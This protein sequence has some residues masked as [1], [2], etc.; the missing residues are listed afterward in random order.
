MKYMIEYAVRTAGLSHDQNFA[1][2]DA[3][4]RAFGKWQPEPGLT[5]EAFVGH[6]NGDSGY[7]LVQADD[8]KVVSSF[9]SKFVYWN[10][11]NVVPVVDIGE[12]VAINAESLAWAQAA[13]GS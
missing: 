5:V 10:D 11:V 6:L 1:K 12:T 4:L 7:V 9:V 2:Q 3:L 13:S 8:P